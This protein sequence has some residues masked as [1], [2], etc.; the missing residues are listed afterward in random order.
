MDYGSPNWTDPNQ[1]PG[2]QM[3][4][5]NGFQ[6]GGNSLDSIMKLVMA[7]KQKQG[8]NPQVEMSD[9][10]QAMKMLQ[11]RNAG[12]AGDTGSGLMGSF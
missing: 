7:K 5:F 4:P 12:F 8:G 9:L 6:T 11:Q 3:Q 1:Q 10:A 2:Y